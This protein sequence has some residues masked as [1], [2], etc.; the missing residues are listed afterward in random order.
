[1]TLKMLPPPPPQH[2]SWG[3]SPH[4][5]FALW[6]RLILH[7]G[8]PAPMHFARTSPPGTAGPSCFV[9]DSQGS[10]QR[11]PGEGGTRCELLPPSW[12]CCF[13]EAV[14]AGSGEQGY[15]SLLT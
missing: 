11:M 1:M 10:R 7:G 5:R 4:P 15:F 8:V 14:K 2:G 13:K 6:S 9:Q 3:P 12:A